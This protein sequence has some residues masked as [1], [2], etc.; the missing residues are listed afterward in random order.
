MLAD[1]SIGETKT[2]KYLYYLNGRRACCHATGPY[3]EKFPERSGQIA[4]G[5][6]ISFRPRGTTAGASPLTILKVGIRAKPESRYFTLDVLS[7]AN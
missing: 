1:P 6:R 3:H 4:A 2:D 7:R 5:G